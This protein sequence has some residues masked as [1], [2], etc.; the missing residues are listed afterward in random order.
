MSFTCKGGPCLSAGSRVQVTVRYA[1]TLPVLGAVFG[2]SGRGAIP[3]SATHTE[4]VD[5]YK[6]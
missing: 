2:D 3:V 5:R 1:V 4:Y 6:P